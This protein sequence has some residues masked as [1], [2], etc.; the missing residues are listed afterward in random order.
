[1]KECTQCKERKPYTE[2]IK[3]GFYH[4]SMCNGCR[5]DYNKKHRD[6]IAKIK[7]QKLW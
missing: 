1:M 6:K 5:K 2:Y 4:H 3:V 7:K